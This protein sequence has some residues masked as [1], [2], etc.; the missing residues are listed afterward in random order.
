[1]ND[2]VDCVIKSGVVE[3]ISDDYIKVRIHNESA[4]SMCYSKGV[5]TSLGS[6]Q[7]TIDVEHDNRHTVKPGDTV[8]I[9]MVSS[10]GFMAVLFGY[11]LPFVLLLGTLLV[12]SNYVTEALAA[13]IAIGILIPYYLILY[14]Y[15]NRMRRYF[16]FTLA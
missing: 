1:M 6:G 12:V 2:K 3:S 5:C 9:Q 16:R 4:C 15:K 13:L 7:R 10:S 8:D 11:I 14:L